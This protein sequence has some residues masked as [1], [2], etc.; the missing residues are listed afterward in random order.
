MRCWVVVWV[1]SNLGACSKMFVPHDEFLPFWGP[2]LAFDLSTMS[3]TMEVGAQ[4]ESQGTKNTRKQHM[5]ENQ[6]KQK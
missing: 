4:K 3:K 5:E 2:S 1:R 6:N